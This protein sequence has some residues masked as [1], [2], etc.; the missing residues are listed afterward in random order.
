M[1]RGFLVERDPEM[2]DAADFS[3]ARG[4]AFRPE[5]LIFFRAALRNLQFS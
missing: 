2:G 4:F 3:V 1:D 5:N